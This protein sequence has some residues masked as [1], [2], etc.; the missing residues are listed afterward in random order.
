MSTENAGRKMFTGVKIT[1]EDKGEVEALF[2]PYD[3]IDGD[4]DLTLPGAFKDGAAVKIGAWN[5]ESWYAEL[6]IGRGKIRDTKEGGVLEGKFFLSTQRGR[7]T[8]EVVKELAELGEWSY[9]YDVLE[10]GEVT[11][12]L[13]QRG[14]Q[15]VLKSLKVIEVAPVLRGAGVNTQTLSVKRFDG[16][17]PS[18]EELLHLCDRCSDRVKAMRSDARKI[19]DDATARALKEYM[20]FKRTQSGLFAVVGEAGLK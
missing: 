4:F 1:D 18:D 16:P 10:S 2:A 17:A 19:E 3:S 12:E 20:R 7:E 14:V 13:R 5:H 9:G 6:P 15:R 11:D 8:F